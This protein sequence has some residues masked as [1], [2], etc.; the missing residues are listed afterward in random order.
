ML[1]ISFIGCFISALYIYSDC[2]DPLCFFSSYYTII[3]Q[4]LTL[5]LWWQG[6]A[7]DSEAKSEELSRAV[8]E[9]HKLLKDAGEGVTITII[10]YYLVLDFLE[11]ESL[12]VLVC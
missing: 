6:A 8:E 4:T 10:S 1:H 9:L 2:N 12:N 11:G 3:L 5:L 7:A